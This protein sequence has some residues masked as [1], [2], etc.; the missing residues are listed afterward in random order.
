MNQILLVSPKQYVDVGLHAVV[1]FQ[2]LD[3]LLS[4][5]LSFRVYGLM[6]G[7]GGGR[8]G[9][10][11]LKPHTHICDVGNETGEG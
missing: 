11:M 2:V 3:I 6:K 5:N 1:S 7:G 9:I 4:P 8:R 10:L